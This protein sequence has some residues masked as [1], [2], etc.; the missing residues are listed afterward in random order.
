MEALLKTESTARTKTIVVGLGK[1]GLSCV[2]F[3]CAQGADVMVVD[4]RQTPP[5]LE[6]LQREF[7]EVEIALGEFDEALFA[8][9]KD[10][11]VSP[12]ISVQTPAIK[13]AA[14]NGA[15]VMGDIE[16]FAQ[17]AK[18][19]V[20]AITGSNGKS[21]VTTLV[22]EMAKAAKKDVR[23]G[24]NIGTPVLELLP[25][26]DQQDE[27]ELYVLELSSFQLETTHSLKPAAATILNVSQDHLDR[28]TDMQ[29][30]VRAKQ[31]IYDHAKYCVI[32]ADDSVA[33]RMC[34][35][36][37]LSQCACAKFTLNQPSTEKEYGVRE[38]NGELWMAKGGLLLM[39]VAELKIAGM[40]NVANT[41]AAIALGDV[42]GLPM[43]AMLEAARNFTGLPHRCQ[44]VAER[45]GVD[46]YNDSKATNV[47]S[48]EAAIKGLNR[49][50][51]LIAG[52]EGKDQDFSPLKDALADT[53][54]AVVLMGRDA[55][56]IESA[57]EGV[58]PVVHV[59]SMQAA[60]EKAN[61]LVQPGDAVL[62]SPACASFDMFKGFEDR[63]NCFVDAVQRSV[64]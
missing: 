16:L 58:V 19:P 33:T 12:G 6:E 29:D 24:G 52:G 41:L 51:V 55:K 18:A 14:Q 36:P 20:I 30:Y 21:T 10:L 7:P 25:E 45:N 50:L 42:V 37:C 22:Y 38:H 44:W 34:G 35:Y 9:A 47:G 49:P 5:G 13:N 46:W 59:D 11:I 8:D 32:N 26:N 17:Q 4:S 28:Y 64:K 3:L 23:I 62:L 31:R 1:T 60:V 27:A 54:R 43:D 63:G 61:E 39:P 2:R 57:L 56:L 15:G 48:A 53:A 40:H